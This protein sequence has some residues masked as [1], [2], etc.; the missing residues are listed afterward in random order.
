[1]VEVAGVAVDVDELAE[2]V[3]MVDVVDGAERVKVAGMAA[4]FFGTAAA[5]FFADGAGSLFADFLEVSLV[6]WVVAGFSG[7]WTGVAAADGVVAT[8]VVELTGACGKRLVPAVEETSF[9]V[10]AFR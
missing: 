5:L 1:M 6:C 4:G 10:W 2:L 9:W 3:G 8:G 7:S